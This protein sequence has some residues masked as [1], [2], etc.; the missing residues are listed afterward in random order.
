MS[1][2]D[3]PSQWT[4]L[5]FSIIS[6]PRR[7]R[8]VGNESGNLNKIGPAWEYLEIYNP[9]EQQVHVATNGLS[10]ASSAATGVSTPST[11]S[12]FRVPPR[13]VRSWHTKATSLS[14]QASGSTAVVVGIALA[15]F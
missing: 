13:Q 9:S 4:G 5:N 6:T 12:R 14:L 10:A 2:A 3:I 1:R 15:R 11:Q 8:L 7:L